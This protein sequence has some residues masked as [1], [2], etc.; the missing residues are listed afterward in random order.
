[1]SRNLAKMEVLAWKMNKR[2]RDF[3]ANAWRNIKE[4]TAKVPN[5]F[6]KNLRY[7]NKSSSLRQQS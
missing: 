5:P 4:S 3:T 2:T 6:H 7:F 1:M